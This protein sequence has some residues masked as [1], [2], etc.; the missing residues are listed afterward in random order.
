MIRALH[1]IGF[2]SIFGQTVE[3]GRVNCFIGTSRLGEGQPGRLRPA[4][5]LGVLN[6]RGSDKSRSKPKSAARLVRPPLPRVPRLPRWM[7]TSPGFRC[8]PSRLGYCC[9]DDDPRGQF[10]GSFDRR[11]S[12][13]RSDRG[14]DWKDDSFNRRWRTLWCPSQR[15]PP[16]S[17]CLQAPSFPRLHDPVDLGREVLE[18]DG[19]K[20]DAGADGPSVLLHSLRDLST[21]RDDVRLEK[22][23][24]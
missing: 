20:P 6:I 14:K 2:K 8:L 13:P 23:F 7:F 9:W 15:L 24:T 22:D 17:P 5:T 10:N 11:E 16:V 4:A 21:E 1:L 3:L 12:P 19:P 18:A